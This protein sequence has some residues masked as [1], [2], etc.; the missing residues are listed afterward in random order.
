M[1]NILVISPTYNEAENIQLFIDS[2][3]EFSNLSLLIIDDNSPDGTSEIVRSNMEN[4][5]RL[6]IISRSEKL[7]LGTAYIEGF[8]W[9][10]NSDYDYCV[11]MDSDFSHSFD[12]LKKILYEIGKYDLVIG[13]R[14]IVGGATEGW[15]LYR[16]LLSKYANKVSKTVLRSN[17]NDLT[18]GFKLLNKKVVSK[19]ME[20]KPK[21]NGYTFQIEINIII[22]KN[23]FA[24]K[25]VPIVFKERVLGKSKMNY[26][27]I[28]EAIYF[29]FKQFLIKEIDLENGEK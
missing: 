4:N 18:G 12:D 27:I 6:Q 26:R 23:L 22:E 3:F 17:I 13:S 21:S 16:R 25:E 11:Q 15:G 9:F 14:Y 2:V 1:S 29:L 19:I 7:G 20:T 5:S 10:L 24:I 28:I 8:S